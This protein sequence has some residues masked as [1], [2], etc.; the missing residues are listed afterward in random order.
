MMISLFSAA[1]TGRLLLLSLFLMLAGC[2]TLS[3]SS[4]SDPSFDRSGYVSYAWSLS[5]GGGETPSE[6]D[7]NP[8]VYSRI[9]SAVDRELSLRGYKLKTTGSVDFIVAVHAQSR[10]HAAIYE[11]PLLYSRGYYRGQFY[12]Y[13]PWWGPFS[14]PYVGYYREGVL[15]VDVVDGVQNKLVWRGQASG[16]LK[17]YRDPGSMQEDI[18]SAVSKIIELF[19]PLKREK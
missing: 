2:Y 12:R 7:M 4:D 19:S 9:K 15:A 5:P 8:F 6:L 13:D 3:L 18:D 11:D 14:R 10:L 1:K 16:A 17:G